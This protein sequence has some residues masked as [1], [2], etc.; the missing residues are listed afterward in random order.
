M[1]IGPDEDRES[2]RSNCPETT[3]TPEEPEIRE[4]IVVR[5]LDELID[6]AKETATQHRLATRGEG[7]MSPQHEQG[8]PMHTES[9]FMLIRRD[10]SLSARQQVNLIQRERQERGAQQS[11][12]MDTFF[13]QLA[14]DMDDATP[15][16]TKKKYKPIQDD[17]EVDPRCYNRSGRL[18]WVI[19]LLY[20]DPR[21][22]GWRHRE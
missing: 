9:N 18:T 6:E 2:H 21:L 10:T 3:S 17:F 22:C 13:T 4:E 19:G 5:M 20:C 15:A 1:Q 11:Q 12:S 16:G 7:D 14:Q 8:I